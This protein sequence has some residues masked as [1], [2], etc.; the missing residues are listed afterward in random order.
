M[1][2][3]IVLYDPVKEIGAIVNVDNRIGFGPAMIGPDAERALTEF[4]ESFEYDPAEVESAVL[5]D[6]FEQWAGEH[7]LPSEGAPGA[8]LSPAGSSVE[9]VGDNGVA[10]AEATAAASAGEPPA[11]QP[12]DTDP[13]AG[14]SEAGPVMD[15][16]PTTG[17]TVTDTG[18]DQTTY[19]GTCFACNGEGTITID[20]AVG[21]VLCSACRGSG[22]LPPPV[23]A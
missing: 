5:R 10:L 9:S 13:E 8:P 16:I 2:D 17:P 1:T 6:W 7:F 3:Y 19:V 23:Q 20:P 15:P 11:P 22:H 12:A 4:M 21:P 14:E 18:G